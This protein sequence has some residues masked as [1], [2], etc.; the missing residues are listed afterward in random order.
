MCLSVIGGLLFCLFS[1]KDGVEGGE[2]KRDMRMKLA[3]IEAKMRELERVYSMAVNKATVLDAKV[4]NKWRLM[5]R[6][7]ERMESSGVF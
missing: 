3:E 1:C 7:S 5:E 2:D 6:E 4:R